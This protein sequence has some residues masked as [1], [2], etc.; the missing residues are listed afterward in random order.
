MKARSFRMHP[1]MI[2]I[3]E[4]NMTKPKLR[5]SKNLIRKLPSGERKFLL[6]EMWNM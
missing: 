4:A 6:E 5:K 2:S 1:R 3:L